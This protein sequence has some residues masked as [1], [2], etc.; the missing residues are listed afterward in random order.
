[1]KKIHPS[2]QFILKLVG[3][4]LIFYGFSLA[5]IGCT[6]PEGRMYIP[7][8]AEK[9]NLVEGF[10]MFLL[11]TSKIF[12]TLS[13]FESE[14]LPPYK[15]SV[16]NSGIKLVYSCMGY[17][18]MSLW[19]ALVIAYPARWKQKILPILVGLLLINL[20]NILRIGGLAMMYSQGETDIFNWINHHTLFNLVVYTT[21]FGVYVVWIRKLNYG[22]N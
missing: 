14:V 11:K 18:L 9:L 7:F 16:G 1:M 5:L 12:T 6:A 4:Y 17:G 3:L 13:G 15:L 8:L 20:L 22:K 19:M 21:M 2:I 10:R